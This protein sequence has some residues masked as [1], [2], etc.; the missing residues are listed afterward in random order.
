MIDQNDIIKLKDYLI[1]KELYNKELKIAEYLTNIKNNKINLLNKKSIKL[2]K[3]YLDNLE[4]DSYQ[5][6]ED[7]KNSIINLFQNNISITYGQAGTG[8]SSIIKALILTLEEF[9]ITKYTTIELCFLTPTTKAKSRIEEIVSNS[10][11]D[12]DYYT[13][14]T[15]QSFNAKKSNSKSD[16]NYDFNIFIIDETSMIDIEVL[17]NFLNL[18]NTKNT[19]IMFLGDYRQLPSIGIGNIL[20]D[21]I[22]SDVLPLTELTQTY[23]Y[24]KLEYLK[25][26][27]NNILNVI[28]LNDTILYRESK[29][30]K[31]ID[32][33]K[34]KNI[35]EKIK[36]EC[37]K[38]DI[39]ITP[40]N[41][42]ITK[43][44][45]IIRNEL[46]PLN[47]DNIKLNEFINLINNNNILL[48][49]LNIDYLIQNKTNDTISI[50]NNNKLIIFY[51]EIN[52]KCG[53]H[54]YRIKDKI[55]HT[56]N[57][58][59]KDLYNGLT[60]E[61]SIIFQIANIKYIVIKRDDNQKYKIYNY[62]ENYIYHLE[63][64]YM[65]TVHKSQ[66][67]EYNNV[68][69]LLDEKTISHNNNL[70]YTAFTRTKKCLT[71]VSTTN[72]LNYGITRKCER[73]TL[74]CHML[75]YY[76]D[77]LVAPKNYLDFKVYYE[78]FIK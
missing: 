35:K 46:N 27:L 60:G 58:K 70:L 13:I 61:I 36:S 11:D 22:T 57:D 59:N 68:M 66:G 26:I 3:D 29:E 63:P 9:I 41:K 75:K 1:G 56:H 65:I 42:E 14:S 45:N 38:N 20:N 8:K 49:K 12:N 40:L 4:I 76:N 34:Y 25:N 78:M 44:T 54:I 72:I 37:K 23:R 24:N 48:N 69:I 64:A 5:L 7:Q 52:S 33:N 19:I 17:Y 28:Q 50:L 47:I 71:I 10:R 51:C 21:M 16:I 30:F 73:D 32:K 6:D 39:I 62:E 55:I 2:I 77:L 31:F 15:I 18:V 43:Y 67:L 74:L 53:K